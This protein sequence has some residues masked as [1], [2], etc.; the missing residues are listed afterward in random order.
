MTKKE[1]LITGS[2]DKNSEAIAKLINNHIEWI[3][4][5]AYTDEEA[6]EKFHQQNFD[7][8]ILTDGIST[9]EEKK[10]RKIFTVQNPD[11]IIM[12]HNYADENL[13]VAEITAALEKFHKARR[14]S[15]SLVDDALKNAGLN[16]IVQ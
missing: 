10:L 14:P 9:E 1:I 12:S 7:V 15:F 11:I 13:L 5:V 16:I 2:D 8:V 6:I 4:T 3:I